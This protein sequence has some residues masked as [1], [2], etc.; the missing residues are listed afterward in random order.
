M[1]DLEADC[2]LVPLETSQSDFKASLYQRLYRLGGHLL[3]SMEQFYNKFY[4]QKLPVDNRESL[5]SNAEF[6][7]R[8]QSLLNAALKVA[9]DHFNIQPHGTLIDRCRRLEQAGWDRIYREDI[10]HPEKLSVLER[11]LA[12]RIAAEANLRMWHMRLVESFVA[13]TGA[14][15]SEK[16][17][18]ERFA[19]TALIMWDTIERI[20]GGKA[21]SRPKLGLQRVQMTVGEPISVS[22]R[23]EQYQASRSSAK[24]A[25]TELTRSLQIALEKTIT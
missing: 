17:T 5:L 2:G 16:P 25:V 4:Y 8:L 20:K 18:A 23:Q 13:V 10:K 19:E 15:V 11:S 14:Y 6:T 24:Q 22:D 9:E 1:S 12:N 7:A 3:R 21:T